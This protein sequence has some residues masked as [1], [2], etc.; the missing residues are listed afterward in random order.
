MFSRFCLIS[1]EELRTCGLCG[2]PMMRF[3]GFLPGYGSIC[4]ECY[5]KVMKE[6]EDRALTISQ[7]V[8]KNRDLFQNSL[9]R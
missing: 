6:T 9:N 4:I 3:K 8:H 1:M 5:L 7:L 2:K